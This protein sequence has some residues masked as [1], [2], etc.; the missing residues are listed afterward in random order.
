[1]GPCPSLSSNL[2]EKRAYLTYRL[3]FVNEWR[4]HS[5]LEACT[6]AETTEEHWLAQLPLLW[7]RPISPGMVPSTES[8]ALQHQ[9]ATR[10][11]PTDISTGQFDGENYSTESRTSQICLVLCLVNDDTLKR[12]NQYKCPLKTKTAECPV[13][14]CETHYKALSH[15]KR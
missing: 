7:C 6:E 1:M 11:H 8:R 15:E 5:N 10:K 9:L 12:R 14:V 3:Q 4:Q 2:Q 13:V